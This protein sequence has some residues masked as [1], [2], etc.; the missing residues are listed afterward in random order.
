MRS[1]FGN[2]A[3]TIGNL[4]KLR[5]ET[6]ERL[7]RENADSINLVDGQYITTNK[8]AEHKIVIQKIALIASS[9]SLG[10]SD[11]T[12]TIKTNRFGYSFAIDNY[13]S[14]VQGIEAEREL[15]K[16]LVQIFNS[17]KKYDVVVLIRGG[18]GKTDFLVFDTYNLSR[19]VAKFPTPIITGIGHHED[20]SIVDLMA[21]THTNAPTKAAEFI[22]SH[23]KAFEDSVLQVQQSIV[24]KSQQV[25]SKHFQLLSSINST[26]VNKARNLIA[27][28]KEG[29]ASFNTAVVNSTKTILFDNKSS[30]LNIANQIIAKPKIMT[31]NKI[32]DLVNISANL[33]VN[34]QK[35]LVSVNSNL[36]NLS[37]QIVPQA[38]KIT[39]NKMNDLGNLTGNLEM[40]SRKYFVNKGGYLRHYESVVRLMSPVNI[41]KKGFA[42]VY[43]EDKIVSNAEKI[44]EGSEIEVR[45]SNTQLT[46]K[47]KSKKQ[48]DGTEFNL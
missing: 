9:N 23:N 25:F 14:T 15:V 10:Y 27:A 37:K 29:L 6:L 36:L 31:S 8:R 34:T 22:I 12:N 4:A 39:S 42:I 33:Q 11:F 48:N 20:V 28:F 43:F 5:Q 13:F 7:L 19:A 44:S 26:V 47:V 24:I 18:G 46:A 41:L 17:G 2:P 38:Q 30:L 16:A 21:H 45:L 40:N 3:Y 32:K 1:D 35:Y